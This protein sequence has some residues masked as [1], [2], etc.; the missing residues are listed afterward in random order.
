[1]DSDSDRHISF[2]EFREFLLKNQWLK[3]GYS[4]PRG[5]KP[6]AAVTEEEI[7]P[8]ADFTHPLV[9]SVDRWIDG[10]GPGPP[11]S[12]LPSLAATT[13]YPVDRSEY[14]SN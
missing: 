8:F 5:C 1:M 2:Y 9:E 13:M 12:L 10:T 4:S 7:V 14:N 6:A 3:A 11:P